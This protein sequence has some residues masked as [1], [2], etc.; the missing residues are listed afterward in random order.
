MLP[1]TRTRA[2]C[3]TQYHIKY[4]SSERTTEIFGYQSTECLLSSALHTPCVSRNTKL[5]QSASLA[6]FT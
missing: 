5:S 1:S 3:A 4:M 6:T 2:R